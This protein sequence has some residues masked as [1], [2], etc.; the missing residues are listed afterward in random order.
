VLEAERLDAFDDLYDQDPVVGSDGFDGMAIRRFGWLRLLGALPVGGDALR[1]SCALL[2]IT[3]LHNAKGFMK[4]AHGV[5]AADARA[6]LL[7]IGL[8]HPI[9]F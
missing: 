8:P 9:F 2:Y 4:E 3:P 5:G 6:P 7:C 1:S